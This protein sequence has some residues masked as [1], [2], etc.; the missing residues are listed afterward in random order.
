[1]KFSKLLEKD[2]YV[3]TDT[4]CKFSDTNNSWSDLKDIVIESCKLGLFQGSKGKFSPKNQLTN[5]QAIAII[6]RIIE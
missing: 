1:V 6:I 3:K 4:Q 5:A 2:T